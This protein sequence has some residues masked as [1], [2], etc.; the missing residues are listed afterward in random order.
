MKCLRRSPYIDMNNA[1]QTKI[2]MAWSE[3]V[4][5][6]IVTD[7]LPYQPDGF[8]STQN[9]IYYAPVSDV[10]LNDGANSPAHPLYMYYCSP[11]VS[12]EY[13]DDHG[14]ATVMPDEVF[15]AP[16]SKMAFARYDRVPYSSS[17]PGTD[18]TGGT[19][20]PWEYVMQSD[21][22]AWADFNAG[23][24]GFDNDGYPEDNR[25]SMF[26]QRYDGSIKPCGQITGG[27]L[28]EYM[29]FGTASLN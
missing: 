29:D 10:D 12:E 18:E 26:L 8:V 21:H 14:A 6:I 23:A 22:S 7:G 13:N 24:F 2:R 25:I 27:F 4:W 17:L 16:I 5:D 1:S 15:S 3:A 20:S 19:L 28:D 9:G 11:V